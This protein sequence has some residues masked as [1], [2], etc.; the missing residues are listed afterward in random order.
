MNVDP[1]DRP[2]SHWI[3]LW[4]NRGNE[5]DEEECVDSFGLPLPRYGALALE[6]W[7]KTS[8]SYVLMNHRSLQTIDSDSCG[9]YALMFLVHCS[10]GGKLETFL[11]IFI[12]HDF[13]KNDNRMAQ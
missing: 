13:V 5:E 11:N 9:A 1:H 2:G 12:H 3:A 4:T 8:W 6:R 7:L 10:L